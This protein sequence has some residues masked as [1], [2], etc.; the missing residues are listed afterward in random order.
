M[1]GSLKRPA[2][3]DDLLQ[4]P[5]HLVAEIIDGEL[6]TS[7]RPATR[8]AH[9]GAALLSE[10]HGAFHQGHGPGGWWVL[11]EPELHFNND[12]L[13]P[14]IA[15]WR[16]ERLPSLPDAAFFTA[17]PD[18]LCEVLS[19]MTEHTDRARKMR[20]YAREQVK[21]VWLV[22]PI[23]RRIEVYALVGDILALAATHRDDDVASIEPFDAVP[24]PLNRL[25]LPS[26]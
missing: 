4:V 12:V 22:E 26:P 1:S 13:V 11:H 2:T 7:P 17:A 5:D 18:W 21:S 9:T 3:Y 15:G 14:D 20:M 6:I 10:I 23:A 24:L 8:Q 16:R 19:P 25:W